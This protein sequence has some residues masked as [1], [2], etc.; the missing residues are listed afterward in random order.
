MKKYYSIVH[1]EYDVKNKNRFQWRT[2]TV[3]GYIVDTVFG[4]RYEEKNLITKNGPGWRITHIP[5]GCLLVSTY[6]ETKEDAIKFARITRNL[7]GDLL[8]QAD[9]SLL[10][11]AKKGSDDIRFHQFYELKEKLNNT[12]GTFSM[13]RIG[14][15]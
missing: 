2:R 5:S 13:D 11:N 7:F 14:E 15:L 4:V 9:I 8:K 12:T 3:S 6:F 10:R 1:G